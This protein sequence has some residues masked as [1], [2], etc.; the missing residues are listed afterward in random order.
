MS[1]CDRGRREGGSFVKALMRDLSAEET[2]R[3]LPRSRCRGF[4][5]LRRFR[6]RNG[7]EWS[8][9]NRRSLAPWAAA[10]GGDLRGAC[11]TSG[12]QSDSRAQIAT[13]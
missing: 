9:L 6:T 11:T 10:K 2:L 8:V 1:D 13:L 5:S 3:K 7:A 12:G 4:A